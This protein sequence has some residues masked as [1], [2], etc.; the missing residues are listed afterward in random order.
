MSTKK[1][2][3]KRKTPTHTHVYCSSSQK[4]SFIFKDIVSQV[5]TMESKQI[6]EERERI[7]K[8]LSKRLEAHDENRK[9]AQ[10]N[11][12]KACE[13]LRAQIKGLEGKVENDLEEK[14]TAEDN[15]LQSAY[16]DLQMDGGE[17]ISKMIQK[18]KAELLVE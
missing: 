8:A 10:K 16:E 17:D 5:K 13:G 4:N 15:R 14:F 7:S 3:E 12:H 6:E 1:K 2:K 18:A 9:A 11:L